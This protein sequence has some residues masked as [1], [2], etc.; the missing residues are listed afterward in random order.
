MDANISVCKLIIIKKGEKNIP[1]LT[2][3][4]VPCYLGPK[5]VSRTCKIFNISREEDVYLFVIKSFSKEGQ[6]PRTKAPKDQYL[7]TTLCPPA[8]MLVYYSEETVYKK[9]LEKSLQNM[10][11]T[12]PR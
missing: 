7:V 12:W 11:T 4:N 2:D 8:Q 1:R 5:R 10:L 9:K 6:K 3:S